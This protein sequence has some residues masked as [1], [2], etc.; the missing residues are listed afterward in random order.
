[1]NE[2]IIY[3]F[4]TFP[5]KKELEKCFGTIFVLHNLKK[6]LITL[7]EKIKKEKPVYILGIAKSMGKY[8][9]IEH[10]AVNQFNR[11]GIIDKNGK[12]ILSLSIPKDICDEFSLS[13]KITTSFCNYSMY[14]VQKFLDDKHLPIPF[15]FVHVSE[16]NISSLPFLFIDSHEK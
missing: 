13:K 1:M 8:S 16:K 15:S 9:V 4:R 12:R 5:H 2:F 7:T 6:D 10:T 14:K 11:K 3:T